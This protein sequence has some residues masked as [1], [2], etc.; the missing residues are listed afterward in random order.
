MDNGAIIGL[1][2]LITA[3]FTGLGLILARIKHSECLRGCCEL[4]T[5]SPTR[6]DSVLSP[7][8]PP[9]PSQHHARKKSNEN[10]ED[11]TIEIQV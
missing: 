5:R 3:I 9:T 6:M 7:P 11:T 1:V 10:I 2:A 8:P 4:D